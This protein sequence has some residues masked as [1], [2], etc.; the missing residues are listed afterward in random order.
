MRALEKPAMVMSDIDFFFGRRMIKN[1][2]AAKYQK[3]VGW[4]DWGRVFNYD[5]S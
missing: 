4:N 2:P 1:I 3:K 5:E